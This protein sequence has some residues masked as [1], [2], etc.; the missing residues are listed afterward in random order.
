MRLIIACNK[1]LSGS[2]SS[3]LERG[4]ICSKLDSF[5]HHVKVVGGSTVAGNMWFV[6]K[7][8]YLMANTKR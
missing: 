4:K 7:L 6:C 3:I 5:K 1:L 8:Q 2:A